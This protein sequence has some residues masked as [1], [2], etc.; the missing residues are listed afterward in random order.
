MELSKKNL[1]ILCKKSSKK[2]CFRYPIYAVNYHLIVGNTQ[3][4]KEEGVSIVGFFDSSR[5]NFLKITNGP[6]TLS[7][8]WVGTRRGGYY[9]SKHTKVPNMGYTPKYLEKVYHAVANDFHGF[10]F[11]K[12]EMNGLTTKIIQDLRFKKLE[13]CSDGSGIIWII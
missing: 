3:N 10:S 7:E 4:D 11:G 1:Q 9:D 2:K 5:T 8:H 6:K 12:K 13:R